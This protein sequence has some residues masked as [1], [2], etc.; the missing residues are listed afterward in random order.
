MPF[1][2]LLNYSLAGLHACIVGRTVR[3]GGAAV[4]PV[5]LQTPPART[6]DSNR[7]NGMVCNP[8]QFSAPKFLVY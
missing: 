1:S 5:F 6:G 7:K 8:A 4:V 2:C 3:E